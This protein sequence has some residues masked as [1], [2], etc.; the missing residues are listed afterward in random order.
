MSFESWERPEM[1]RAIKR[2]IDVVAA[3]IGLVVL[4]PLLTVIAVA[5]RVS[6]G[7]PVLFRQRR[8]GYRGRPFTLIKFRTMRATSGTDAERLTWLGRFLRRLSLDELPQLWN[9]LKGEMSLVGPRP[10]LLEYLP[11][12]SPEQARRHL[13]RP[14]ITGWAQINGR[15]AI[16]WDEKF[17]L[18][19]WYVDHWSLR[20]DLAILL[21]TVLRVVERRGIS[22]E[23]HATAPE[24]LPV[25]ASIEEVLI[26]CPSVS[27]S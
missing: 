13:A 3:S 12:Y 6:M 26:P 22:A 16:S 21:A 15:N 14:G 17:R 11:R 27:A 1:P 10:L 7:R 23:G 25:A 20:L 4:M 2:L 9:V 18:D 24:F 5:I 8:P 19:T